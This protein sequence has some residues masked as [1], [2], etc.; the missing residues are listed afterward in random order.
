MLNSILGKKIGMTQ[1]F[2]QKDEVVPVTVIKINNLYA[3]QIKSIQVDGYSALQVGLL[4]K[5]Y[6]GHA[7]DLSWNKN[8]KKYFSFIK[9]FRFEGNSEDKFKVGQEISLNDID[10]I[11]GSEVKVT[12]KSKG[13]GFQGVVK[14]WGFAGGP[15]SHG[16]NFHRKPGALGGMRTQGEVVKGKKLPGHCGNRKTTTKG[17]RVASIDKEGGYLFVKGAVP[18][19]KDSLVVV[20]K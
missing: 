11:Q 5:R 16:S 2:N 15:G 20:S 1:L 17:L 7:F 18:G 13:L 6:I 19:K 8:K 9:E 12:S 3:T 14:R 4:K 10:V